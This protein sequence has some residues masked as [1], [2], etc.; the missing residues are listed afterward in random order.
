MKLLNAGNVLIPAIKVMKDIGYRVD[1][2][3]ETAL[4]SAHKDSNEFFAEDPVA[5]LGLI[6]LFE[7]RGE[8][9]RISDKELNAIAHEYRMW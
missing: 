7:V 8:N 5:L 3:E 9:W 4:F 2:E 1:F 6:K